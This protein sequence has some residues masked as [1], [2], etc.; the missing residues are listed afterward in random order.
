MIFMVFMC[1]FLKYGGFGG[2]FIFRLPE[3]L[4]CI[5]AF[6]FHNHKRARIF[7]AGVVVHPI[8]S[9]LKIIKNR[10]HARFSVFKRLFSARVAIHKSISLSSQPIARADKRMGRGKVSSWRRSFGFNFAQIMLREKPHFLA[11][12]S[13]RKM[14]SFIFLSFGFGWW[15]NTLVCVLTF[16]KI[17]KIF[18]DCK[19][20]KGKDNFAFVLSFFRGIF[21][22]FLCW[23]KVGQ[24]LHGLNLEKKWKRCFPEPENGQIQKCKQ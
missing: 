1:A 10:V 3:K 18:H 21:D 15:K 2:I 24:K 22:T 16:L 17:T 5:A 11:V 7:R 20:M 19:A 8:T 4:D 12:S 9:R 23:S 14:V 13:M 6:R